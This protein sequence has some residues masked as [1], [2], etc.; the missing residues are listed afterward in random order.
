MCNRTK[1]VQETLTVDETVTKPDKSPVTVAD[2]S[3]QSLISLH[4]LNFFPEDKI[5]GEEDTTELRANGPLREKVVGLVNGGFE[6]G[7]SE[8]QGE[9]AEDKVWSEEE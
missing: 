7:R 8:N 3:A 5:V 1:A 4:L 2:L 9:W 6:K